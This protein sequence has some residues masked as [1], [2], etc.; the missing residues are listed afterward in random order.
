MQKVAQTVQ[1]PRAEKISSSHHNLSKID[2]QITV[3]VGPERSLPHPLNNSIYMV[4]KAGI[5]VREFAHVKG[6]QVKGCKLGI[7]WFPSN[8][9]PNDQWWQ[10]R[11]LPRC[12]PNH[13]ASH[14]NDFK[15]IAR[16]YRITS[17]EKAQLSVPY[18]SSWKASFACPGGQGHDQGAP[19]FDA[20]C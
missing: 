7:Q 6:P 2:F 19:P 18:L 13:Q 17:V 9:S 3:F 8:R 1:S 20:Q 15:G 10:T 4:V 14:R 5:C 16:P 11:A 12:L